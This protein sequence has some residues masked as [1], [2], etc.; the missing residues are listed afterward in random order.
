MTAIW[1][2]SDLGFDDLW[3][4]LLLRHL[5]VP[6]AGLSLVAGNTGLPQVIRNALG[7]QMAYG[8]DAPLFA[9]A[10]RPLRRPPETAER[11]LGPRGM[12]SRGAYLPQPETRP[13]LL[14]AL[15][16]DLPPALPALVR[17]LDMARPG[18]D[19]VLLALGPLSNVAH[20]IERHP[21]SA[22][23]IT[24][25]IWM[26]GSDGPGNHS[27]AAEF[28]ALADPDAARIVAA[29][30]LP[31]EVADL[32]LCRAITFGP[33]D[34]P[35]T[36]P[37]TADLLGGYL[38]IALSRGRAGMAIYDPV[39]ALL[40]ARPDRFGVMR[41]RLSVVTDATDRH[42]ATDFTPDAQGPVRLA[43]P[44]PDPAA[45]ARLCLGALSKE[46]AD[47]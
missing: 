38:D 20:L 41:C 15:P 42:G 18:E 8:I 14:P 10:D 11:I 44:G 13:D 27:P 2:D 31:L 4:L 25:L 19:R 30:G 45:L 26:G 1:V 7:A 37:L 29:S 17:W 5:N 21:A 16:P 36:D 33:G 22:A 43:L 24:R 46:P 28:N 32:M 35:E 9:G 34:L 47:G 12:R 3:A 39:A 6:V 40:A 23:S